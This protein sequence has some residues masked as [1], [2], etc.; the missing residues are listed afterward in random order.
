M[1]TKRS[2]RELIRYVRSYKTDNPCSDC[3]VKYH[4]SVMQ[5]DHKDGSLKE[6]NI[7]SLMWRASIQRVR[8]EIA[9]CELVCANCHSLRTFRKQHGIDDKFYGTVIQS[10]TPEN[11]G[12]IELLASLQKDISFLAKKAREEDLII[13][14]VV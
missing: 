4:Y 8:D 7:N 5:F 9:K 13:R 10:N 14:K 11:I 3:N 2:N 6:A 1:Q 12:L